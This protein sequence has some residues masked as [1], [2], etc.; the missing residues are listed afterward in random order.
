MKNI[1]VLTDFS[2]NASH[3]AESAVVLAGKMHANLLLFHNFQ[4]FPVTPFYAGGALV[5]DEPAWIT[6]ESKNNLN[7]LEKRLDPIADE[8]DE[9]DRRPTI[10]CECNEGNLA[11]NI[12]FIAAKK[13]IE[14]MVM[15]ARTEDPIDHFFFGSDTQSVIQNAPCPVL[16]IPEKNEIKSLNKIVFATNFDRADV[17]A[18]QYLV[19]L[20]KLF[21]CDIEIVHVVKD[22][23]KKAGKNEK[24]ILFKEQVGKLKY[25]KLNYHREN[26]NDVVRRLNYLCK[27][28]G[29][30]LLAVVHHHNSL[31]V[32][33]LRHSL[34]KEILVKQNLP[35]LVFPSK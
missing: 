2:E 30:G 31:F 19:K 1:L 14:L 16:V 33:M 11:E 25:P 13:E 15:G 18:V 10:R 26:G 34:T 8:L 35:L 29:L 20:G 32:R 3:A 24:E 12:K 27:K 9:D 5:V 7:Q 22:E 28:N 17:E 4:G 21:D 23:E 6:E